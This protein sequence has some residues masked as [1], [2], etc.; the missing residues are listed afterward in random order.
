MKESGQSF[1]ENEDGEGEGGPGCEDGVDHDR[2]DV[3]GLQRERDAHHH[4]PQDL[5]GRR[6]KDSVAF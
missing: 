1:H 2:V 4:V 6:N 5:V 3:G